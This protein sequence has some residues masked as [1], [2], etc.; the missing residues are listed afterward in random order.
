M[1]GGRHL[2][3]WEGRRLGTK[4]AMDTGPSAS[5]PWNLSMKPDTFNSVLLRRGQ[6][7]GRAGTWTCLLS[8]ESLYDSACPLPPPALSIENHCECPLASRIIIIICHGRE[9][10]WAVGVVRETIP[11]A[12]SLS[13]VPL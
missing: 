7:W 5:S 13:S 6:R 3:F 12:P 8:L 10:L 1:V 9:W 4:E 11:N 2:D